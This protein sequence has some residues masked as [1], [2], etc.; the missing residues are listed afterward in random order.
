MFTKIIII[1]IAYSPFPFS[2]QVK[3]RKF[4]AM[5]GSSLPHP[6]LFS[7]RPWWRSMWSWSQCWI[8]WPPTEV[9][10]KSCTRKGCPSPRLPP[11]ALPRS[12]RPGMT[13]TNPP[14]Q[15]LLQNDCAPKSR[16]PS[17]T[18]FFGSF[19][20]KQTYN[21]RDVLRSMPGCS[22]WS[23]VSAQRTEEEAGAAGRL[24][25][26]HLSPMN[27]EILGWEESGQRAAVGPGLRMAGP[28]PSE[29]RGHWTVKA[30][31]ALLHFVYGYSVCY[32]PN[33][34]CLCFLSQLP[35]VPDCP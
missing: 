23:V 4:T 29:L 32:K 25:D 2:S 18:P 3:A 22:P 13:E 20:L 10:G 5:I 24:Q 31:L 30:S 9:S 35:F 33:N 7:C 21:L 11:P 27:T 15:P 17:R 19:K 14:G 34:A 16:L 12:R 28:A 26:P 6:L 8:P 1:F